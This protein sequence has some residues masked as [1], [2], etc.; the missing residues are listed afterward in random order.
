[1]PEGQ[2]LEFSGLTKHFGSIAAVSGFTAQV[3]PGVVTGFLGPNGAGKTTTLR[4]L[5]GLIR[6]DAGT[7]TIGGLPYARLAHPL[8]TVGAVLE[9]SSFHPGR[10]AA[11]HL[12]V[13]AQAAG[14]PLSR[15]DETLGLVGLADAAGRKVGGFSLGMRQRLGLAYALLGDPGVLVLDEPSNGLDP[16]GIKWLRGFLRE[17]ARQ[18]RTVLVS[19]HL[20]SEVQQTVDA[21]LIIAQGRLVFQGGLDQ[22]TDPS[23]YTTIVDSPDRAALSAALSDAEVPFEVLRSGLT[24]RGAEPVSVGLIAAASGVPLSALQRR[25][26]ALEEVFLDLVNGVRVHPSA[27]G[28]VPDAAYIAA[29]AGAVEAMDDVVPGD[30]VVEDGDE[31]EASALAAT[32]DAET[33]GTPGGAVAA[34][35]AAGL[36]AAA[37]AQAFEPEEPAA[38]PEER[39]PS[40]EASF[41]VASTGVIDIIPAEVAA[42][43]ATVDDEP[44]V[45]ADVDVDALADIDDDLTDAL[46]DEPDAD[47]P[48]G[49]VSD[50]PWEDYVKTEAD[51][52][53]DRFFHSFDDE[54]N[55]IPGTAEG[56]ASSVADADAEAEVDAEAGVDEADIEAPVEPVADAVEVEVEVDTEADA[57]VETST[58]DAAE[59]VE[60]TDD[61][62]TPE[63][64]ATVD[65]EGSAEPESEASEASEASEDHSPEDDDPGADP[66]EPSSD[67]PGPEADD[68][69]EGEQR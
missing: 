4:A 47:A 42:V 25:G 26:P 37:L 11:N 33:L 13:Y 49:T 3:E 61:D 32:F 29:V 64:P 16:E 68:H 22:L 45:D 59:A 21:L 43:A 14:L 10:T 12:K 18:G 27:S 38:A 46:D 31:L 58:D 24:V 62:S 55:A 66:A 28:G 5:L 44:A 39:H 15:V 56:E 34:G 2:M 48:E 57:D 35:A 1:M 50:R 8:Q 9:A 41:A 65:A 53:A 52:E 51:V 63:A 20:L 60:S 54:G 36:G 69:E 23:E 19:S 7:A 67:E 40:A 30:E 6:A 17:F